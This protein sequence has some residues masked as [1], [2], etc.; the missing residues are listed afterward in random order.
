MLAV[1]DSVHNNKRQGMSFILGD[2][3]MY[4][5]NKKSLSCLEMHS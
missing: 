3:V 1:M 2:W 4:C 5:D